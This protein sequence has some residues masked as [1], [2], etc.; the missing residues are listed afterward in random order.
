MREHLETKRALLASAGYN[1][2][3]WTRHTY[4]YS[5][6]ITLP[7][8]V[9]GDVT[10]LAHYFKCEET[11]EVRRWGFDRTFARDNGGN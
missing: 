5:E 11:G 10:G 9:G 1:Y 6:V 4:A 8:L 2:N 7:R 3:K